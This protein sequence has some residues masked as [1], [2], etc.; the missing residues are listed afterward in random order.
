LLKL[1]RQRLDYM[2]QQRRSSE[3]KTEDNL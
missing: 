2:E 1:V 3:A